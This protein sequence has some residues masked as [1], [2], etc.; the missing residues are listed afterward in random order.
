MTR[1]PFWSAARIPEEGRRWRSE[2]QRSLDPWPPTRTEPVTHGQV[3]FGF[4][5]PF[6]RANRVSACSRLYEKAYFSCQMKC[7]HISELRSIRNLFLNRGESRQDIWHKNEVYISRRWE[8]LCK[9]FM[10]HWRI[11]R[12]GMFVGEWQNDWRSRIRCYECNRKISFLFATNDRCCDVL[13]ERKR[14]RGPRFYFVASWK[15]NAKNVKCHWAC[16]R[17][18]QQALSGCVICAFAKFNIKKR[19]RKNA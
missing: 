4:F 6:S 8:E 7:I 9:T 13:L 3:R 14:R 17:R 10:Q 1:L 19:Q 12:R 18:E 11:S 16:N 5:L 15:I 2:D